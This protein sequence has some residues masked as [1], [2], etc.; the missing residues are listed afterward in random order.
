ML[1]FS[2]YG[3]FFDF[4]IFSML[5]RQIFDADASFRLLD[6]IHFH[7]GCRLTPLLPPY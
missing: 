2:L 3:F 4:S 1:S 5:I 7:E 6:T